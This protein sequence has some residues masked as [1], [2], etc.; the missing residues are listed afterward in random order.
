[1]RLGFPL[2]ERR[3]H[4]PDVHGFGA[5]GQ[6]FTIQSGG[7]NAEYGGTAI[8]VGGN[9][10]SGNEGNGVIQFNGS[11]TSITWTNPLFENW[12][13]FTVGAPV[14][15]AI[16]EP[17]TYALMLAGLALLGARARRRRNAG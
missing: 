15:A 4:E 9:T 10:M 12:Y 2:L 16:P 8:T 14:V 11:L 3:R 1:L 6:S 7:P 13:G 5:L 17:E